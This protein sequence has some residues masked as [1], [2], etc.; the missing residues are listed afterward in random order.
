MTVG[1]HQA[2]P[3]QH[4]LGGG[5]QGAHAF[6][7]DRKARHDKKQHEQQNAKAH[8]NH[9]QRVHQRAHHFLADVLDPRFV[10]LVAPEHHR[11]LPAAFGRGHGCH[12]QRRIH[13]GLRLHRLGQRLALIQRAQQLAQRSLQRLVALACLVAQRLKRFDQGQPGVQQ[14]RQLL[15]QQPKRK[16]LLAA[17]LDATAHGRTLNVQ[18]HAVGIAQ[19]RACLVFAG[20][21]HGVHAQRSLLEQ[22]DPELIHI[23]AP[24]VATGDSGRRAPGSVADSVAT[25]GSRSACVPLRDWPRRRRCTPRPRARCSRSA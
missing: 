24:R 11:Q 16:G 7:Y 6:E 4:G 2:R 21:A 20:G 14:G 23:N 12:Q 1:L 19:L 17:R 13:Q 9:Y 22:T 3:P 5:R 25:R 10:V 15:Q 8:R 18:N